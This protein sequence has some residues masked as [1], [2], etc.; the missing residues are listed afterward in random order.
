M[1]HI[2]TLLVLAISLNVFSQNANL[3]IFNNSGQPFFVILNG[4][5]QNS[6]PKTNVKVQG[7]NPVSYKVK[8]IFADGKT[9][10]IDKSVFLEPN[11]E[12]SAQVVFKKGKGKLKL[13]DLVALN[14]SPYGNGSQVISYRANDNVVYSD[15]QT[16]QTYNNGNAQVNVNGQT[17]TTNSQTTSTQTTT[18]MSGTHTHADGTVHDHNHNVVTPPANGT[19]THADGTVHDHNHQ[20]IS[21]TPQP[22]KPVIYTDGEAIVNANG[23]LTCRNALNNIDLLISEVKAENFSSDKM[24]L[25]RTTLNTKCINSDQAYRIVNTFTFDGDKIEMAKFCYDHMTDKANAKK[26]LDLFTFSS[27]KD[28]LKKYFGTK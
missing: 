23:T 25:V 2:F 26:L 21:N 13:F 27:S 24:Q 6:I 28:E 11:M 16:T 12:Y 9:G 14:T 5:K 10:D 19:H 7:L 8:I 4:V 20:V 3:I 18:H 1:K 17:V 22:L 15:Q